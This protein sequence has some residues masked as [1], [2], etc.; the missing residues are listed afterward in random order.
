MMGKNTPWYEVGTQQAWDSLIKHQEK[1]YHEED[2]PNNMYVYGYMAGRE[3][4]LKEVS[5]TKNK[6]RRKNETR[7]SDKAGSP[8]VTK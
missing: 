8:T 1:T 7:T 3:D 2:Y 5:I 6:H 4:A